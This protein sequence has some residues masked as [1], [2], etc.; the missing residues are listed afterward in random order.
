MSVIAILDFFR[1]FIYDFYYNTRETIRENT[2]EYYTPILIGISYWKQ[3][4]L[5]IVKI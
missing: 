3:K 5:I 1:T 2:I 4:L